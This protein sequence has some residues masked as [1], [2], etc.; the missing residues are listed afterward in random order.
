MACICQQS[1]NF[2]D[3]E[4]ILLVVGHKYWSEWQGLSGTKMQIFRD[5]MRGSRID[6]LGVYSLI[7]KEADKC[8]QLFDILQ[9]EAMSMK[10]K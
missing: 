8:N 10:S 5:G 7:G 4:I 3:V 6:N 9:P 1:L 2:S